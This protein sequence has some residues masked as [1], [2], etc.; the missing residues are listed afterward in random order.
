MCATNIYA[1][2]LQHGVLLAVV[3]MALGL[4]ALALDWFATLLTK[5]SASLETVTM[6]RFTGGALLGMDLVV[7]LAAVLQQPVHKMGCVM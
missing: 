2:Q 4:I 6:I 1:A 5:A 7:F 3:T